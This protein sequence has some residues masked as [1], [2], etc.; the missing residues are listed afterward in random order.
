MVIN[1]LL[2][3]AVV[4]VLVFTL[5]VILKSTWEEQSPVLVN[6]KLQSMNNQELQ[7]E[8]L[9][10]EILK[11]Q[12]ENKKLNSFWGLLPSY[13]TFLT[14]L[15]AVIGIII[16]IWKQINERS[17]QQ[18]LDRRQRGMDRKQREDDS[19]RRLDEKFTSII[20]NLGSESISIQASAAV[21]IITFLKPE[22]R[23]FHDQV[24]MILLANLKIPHS[25]SVNKLLIAGFEKA[26][27]IRLQSAQE[28]YE[29]FVLD[30]SGSNL[31]RVDLSGL[32]LSQADLGFAKLQGANLSN[33]NLSRVRGG[34]ANLENA[35]LSRAN[36]EEARFRKAQLEGAQFHEARLVSADFRQ[37]QL[38]KAQFYRAEMQSAHLEKANIIG[39]K[40]E[41]A[42]LND[43]FFYGT[44]LNA[45][46]L[47]SILKA[48]N[49]QKA[50]FDDDVRAK[51]E[52]LTNNSD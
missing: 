42:N 19:L 22:Y 28:K 18:E 46:S 27:R 26:I 33:T 52:E 50:H 17:R 40:F 20:S 35:R 6:N 25:D 41:Q 21:S 10:Q 34:E 44:R 45:E 47:K 4:F 49:W 39:A 37:T 51:L 2:R 5:T 31:F 14:A 1:R 11:L 30:L 29:E 7:N 24:F 13:A 48:F 16:T 15:V 8:K 3:V 23:V 43:T 9:R 12:L 36:L 32:N 38:T